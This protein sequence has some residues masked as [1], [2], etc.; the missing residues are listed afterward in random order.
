MD[1]YS[2]NHPHHYWNVAEGPNKLTDDDKWITLV[3]LVTSSTR[4]WPWTLRT[5]ST[6]GLSDG[7]EENALGNGPSDLLVIILRPGSGGSQPGDY[8]NI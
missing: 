5:R 6:P 1:Q 2:N 4:P 8:G 7:Q 3:M